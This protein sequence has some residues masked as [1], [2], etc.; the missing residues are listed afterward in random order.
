MHKRY[1]HSSV[2]LCWV[3]QKKEF[4]YLILEVKRWLLSSFILGN[5]LL[6]YDTKSA[7]NDERYIDEILL[8]TKYCISENFLS[9]NYLKNGEFEEELFCT[10]ILYF[11]R[12][13]IITFQ[14][15]KNDT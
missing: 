15:I 10:I 6:D 4:F 12:Y 1:A 7:Q 2:I 8:C 3:I 9:P 13:Y 11:L 14:R 5:W